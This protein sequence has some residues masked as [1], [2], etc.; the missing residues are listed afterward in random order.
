MSNIAVRR[1][2]ELG[3]RGHRS[4]L[5]RDIATLGDLNP[6]TTHEQVMVRLS[7]SRATYFRQLR[8]ARDRLASALLE[9]PEFS[10]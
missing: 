7:V 2:A 10:P 1:S 6:A 8:K 3:P 4:G 9:Q 5:L